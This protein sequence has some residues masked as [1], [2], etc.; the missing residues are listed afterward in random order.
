VDLRVG[1]CGGAAGAVDY[2]TV[3]ELDVLWCVYTS[4]GGG[5][6]GGGRGSQ[7]TSNASAAQ[8]VGSTS[9]LMHWLLIGT[10]CGQ[11]S[12]RHQTHAANTLLL[13]VL[14]ASTS[15]HSFNFRAKP[16]ALKD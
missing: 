8:Q 1:G 7:Y 2:S 4:V 13:T 16:T 6:G 3:F 15:K 5:G 14:Q 12:W 9:M 10:L 11:A